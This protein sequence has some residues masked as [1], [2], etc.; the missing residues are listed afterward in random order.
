MNTP[1]VPQRCSLAAKR[2]TGF[3]EYVCRLW[4]SKKSSL[5]KQITKRNSLELSRTVLF[6]N[7]SADQSREANEQNYDDTVWRNNFTVADTQS[8]RKV[9]VD[10][11]G[12]GGE[13]R[14]DHYRKYQ[15]RSKYLLP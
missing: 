7:H 15:Q 6:Q 4:S 5:K 3:Y 10:C 9:P 11:S 2:K 14:S 13:K 12:I 8:Q 1:S